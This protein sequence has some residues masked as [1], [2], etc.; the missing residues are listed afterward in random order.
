[1]RFSGMRVVDIFQAWDQS[2]DFHITRRELGEGLS[3]I[4]LTLS[5]ELVMLIFDSICDGHNLSYDGF[6]AWYEETKYANLSD[7]ERERRAAIFIQT[8]IRRWV[9]RSG[10]QSAQLT[11]TSLV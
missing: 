3:H 4:G 7:E 11:S 5:D 9:A 8:V 10:F 2:G 6:K 1:M